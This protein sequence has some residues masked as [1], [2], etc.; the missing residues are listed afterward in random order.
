MSRLPAFMSSLALIAALAASGIA[1]AAVEVSDWGKLP[2]GEEVKLYTM[3]ND[4]G[5]VVKISNYGALITSIMVPDKE[6]KMADVALGFDS[7]E[8]YAS[9]ACPYFGAVVGRYGNRIANGQ[10]KIDGKTYDI[11]KNEN[12]ITCLHGGKVGFNKKIWSIEQKDHE[13]AMI[14]KCRMQSKDGEEGFPGNLDVTVTY[15]LPKADNTL[16]VLYG[17]K[18]DKATPV[19]LTQHCYFNLEGAG[20]GDI[21]GHVLSLNADKF[22]VVNET[23]IPTGELRDVEGT[24]FDF[25]EPVAIGERIEQDYDQLKIGGGYDHNWVLNQPEIVEDE[26]GKKQMTPCA[27]VLAPK[28]GR[29]MEVYTTEPGVQF[30]CGNFLDGS[31]TGKGGKAY[32]KRSGFCLETQH[33]PDSPNQ[34]DFPSTILRPGEEYRTVTV[35]RFGVEK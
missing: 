3:T 15:L 35:F 24:P 6:G 16:I 1:S 25:R 26:D 18:T 11:T 22:T 8:G 23:L 10:F 13:K 14:L 34:K 27:T 17:A 20:E 5:M 28:S 21:L 31:L 29:T 7:V 32:G 12:G 2:S 19:N 4:N 9:D 33:Y 30:Y